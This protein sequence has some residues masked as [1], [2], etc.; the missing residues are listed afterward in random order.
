MALIRVTS[1]KLRETAEQL[2]GL[3]QQFQ[4]QVDTLAGQ[5][6]TLASQWEGDA[7]DAFHTAF[8]NDKTQWEA[9]HTLIEQYAVSLNNIAIEYDNKESMNQNIASSRT[10]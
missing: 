9:F 8:N 1:Q 7:K 4:T 3:N 10:Y 5:E 2:R 6:Q